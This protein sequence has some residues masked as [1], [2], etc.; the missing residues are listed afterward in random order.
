MHIDSIFNLEETYKSC[1]Y[2]VLNF[3]NVIQLCSHDFLNDNVLYQNLIKVQPTIR[4]W[5]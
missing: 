5:Q 2:I 4:K 3:L 1:F